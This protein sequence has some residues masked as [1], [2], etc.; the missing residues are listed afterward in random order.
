M[1]PIPRR[2]EAID[3]RTT[4]GYAPRRDDRYDDGSFQPQMSESSGRSREQGVE[5]D[6]WLV[7][8]TRDDIVVSRRSDY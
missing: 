3:S 4:L 8:D 6:R 1:A 5:P 7:P 2:D